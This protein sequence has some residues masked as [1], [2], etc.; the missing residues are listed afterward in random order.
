MTKDQLREA[1]ADVGVKTAA[2]MKKAELVKLYRQHIL[3]QNVS[4]VSPNDSLI[5]GFSSDEEEPVLSL[6]T[7]HINTK[8]KI[9]DLTND[10][11]FFKLRD[12]GENVGPILDST[13]T[14]YERKLTKLL[15]QELPGDEADSKLADV[16]AFSADEDE[17]EEDVNRSDE[18]DEYDV[19]AANGGQ[20]AAAGEKLLDDGGFLKT[21]RSLHEKVEQRGDGSVVRT[22][23]AHTL[24]SFSSDATAVN[25]KSFVP[26]PPKKRSLAPFLAAGLALIVVALLAV[27]VWMN[28]D[29][30]QQFATVPT[31]SGTPPLTGQAPPSPAQAPPAAAAGAR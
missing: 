15:G 23:R 3:E 21:T 13:R 25:G 4:S 18:T 12:L 9:A 8:T 30:G 14:I 5:G 26:P 29:N 1:L 17:Q 22:R 6:D 10:E 19:L 24:K 20:V 28:L 27:A 2:K 11:I 31:S 16:S 7:S